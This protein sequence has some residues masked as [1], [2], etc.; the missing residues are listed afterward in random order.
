[1]RVA[2]T[3]D[4]KMPT[5]WPLA[6]D[7]ARYAGDG[8]AVVLADTRAL[9]KDAAELVEVDYEPLP[10][11]TDV[12]AALDEGAPRVHDEF[13]SNECYVW[14]LEAGEVDKLFAEADVTV[15]ER[16]TRT[17]SYRTRWS[18]AECLCSRPR[19]RVST[20]SGRRHRFPTS[21][22]CCCR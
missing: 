14:K 13:D 9:A 11:V 17:G 15:S 12:G 21:S 20:R 19:P 5:H 4:I 10:A 2:V 22:V 16:Y 1:M 6:R 7:K 3:E 8:V 18:P